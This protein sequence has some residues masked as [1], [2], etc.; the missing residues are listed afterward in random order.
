MGLLVFMGVLSGIAQTLFVY[1]LN[2]G[3]ATF[4]YPFD[5]TRLIWAALV[6]LIIFAEPLALTTIFGAAV[7]VASN[8]YIA[9]RQ[10]LENKA[11]EKPSAEKPPKP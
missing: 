4:V 11:A 2:A 10:G 7:I 3:E 1:S 8:L 6:G 5:F 9:H